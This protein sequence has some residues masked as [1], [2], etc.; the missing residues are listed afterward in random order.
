M[1][2]LSEL[3]HPG[4]P[5]VAMYF[6]MSFLVMWMRCAARG[7]PLGIV[8]PVGSALGIVILMGTWVPD[9][10]GFGRKWIHGIS[11]CMLHPTCTHLLF[12]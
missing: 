6:I 12:S 7:V 5:V 9:L 8:M 4:H 1:V 2:L 11:L 3:L 10:F